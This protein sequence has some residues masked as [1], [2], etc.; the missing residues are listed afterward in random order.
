METEI[1]IMIVEDSLLAGKMLKD[2]LVGRGLS[3]SLVT[4][5]QEALSHLLAGADVPNLIISDLMMPGMSGYELCHTIRQ[6]EALK[7]I[8]L[9]LLTARD[10]L[11]EKI[12]GFEAGADD[13]LVKPVE[14]EELLLRIKAL[15]SRSSRPKPEPASPTPQCHTVSVFSLRGGAGVTSLAVNLA[16]GLHQLWNAPVPLLDLGLKSGHCSLLLNLR[17]RYT[18]TDLIKQGEGEVDEMAVQSTFAKHAAGVRLLAAPIS[19]IEAELIDRKLLTALWPSLSANANHMVIDAGSA[20]TETTLTALDFSDVIVLVTPPELAGLK[21][22][23]DAL[24]TFEALEYESKQIHL[25]INW[26]FPRDGLTQRQIETALRMKATAVIPHER[27]LFL[28]SINTGQPVLL[29][30]GRARASQAILELAKQVSAP[31]MQVQDG[32]APAVERRSVRV[33]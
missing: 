30:D 19:A 25:V 11:K 33:S 18:L 2:Y 28:R 27:D 10:G 3:V 13:Y 4:S 16:L 6:N 9:I 14:P 5:G 15:L 29:S 31:T 26:T 21:A 20:F 17:P 8:P 24:Q 32:A 12:A 1:K 23:T 22:A 7:H